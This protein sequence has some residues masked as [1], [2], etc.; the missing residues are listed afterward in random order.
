MNQIR[1]IHHNVSLLILK[2]LKQ[3]IGK[4]IQIIHT[5]F[6]KC[7][8]T[9][10]IFTLTKYAQFNFLDRNFVSFI[11]IK[12]NIIVDA[13]LGA[14]S[15]INVKII[16]EPKFKSKNTRERQEIYAQL[17]QE[18]SSINMRTGNILKEILIFGYEEQGLFDDN[19]STK[20]LESSYDIKTIEGLIWKFNNGEEWIMTI[21]EDEIYL[22][23]HPKIDKNFLHHYRN[24]LEWKAV[25]RYYIQ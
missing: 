4:E 15:N 10:S 1:K 20:P 11:K 21:S 24:N 22:K 6:L 12:P 19:F 2:K 9:S 23:I 25:F 18:G 13:Y 7:N 8:I 14:I 17:F 3:F 16:E 5:H